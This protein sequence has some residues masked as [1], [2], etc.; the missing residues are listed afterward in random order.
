VVSSNLFGR[1]DLTDG[2]IY[3]LND[4]SKRIVGKLDD[5][6][7]V[8]AYFSKNLPSPYNA[9][10]KYVQDKLEEYRA[11]GKG[12]FRFEFV[13]P[14]DDA[15][16][17]EEAQKHRIPPVQ[18]QVVEQDQFQA[19]KAYMGLVFLYQDRQETIPVV[20]NPIGLEYEVTSA[21]KKL[22]S[23]DDQ[24]PVVGFLS[25]HGEPG[26]DRLSIVQQVFAKQYRLQDVNL[27]DG[28]RGRTCACCWWRRRAARCAQEQLPST[29]SLLPAARS[30][31]CS[32]RSMRIC[33]CSAPCRCGST[34]TNGWPTMACG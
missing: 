26:L 18:V 31:S 34:P 33:R 9:N 21:I 10:S 32:T 22:T 27:A 12:R 13:D 19:K 1:I 11:Y 29:S 24:L 14:G 25:G 2:R 3:S 8:K 7:L 16:L 6:F 17:E 28:A 15:K 20:D 23:D 4:A 30:R 5:T